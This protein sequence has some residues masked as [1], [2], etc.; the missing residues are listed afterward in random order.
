MLGENEQFLEDYLSFRVLGENTEGVYQKA[1]LSWDR[2]T[3]IPITELSKDSLFTWYK[4]AAINLS[5]VTIEKYGALCRIMY[6]YVLEQTGLSSRKAKAE[7]ADLFDV[8]PFKDLRK[9][10]KQ[11][12]NLRD[13][14]VTPHEFQ[15]L[16][17]I[18]RSQRMKAL[19]SLTYETGCRKAEIFSIRLKDIHLHEQYWTVLIEGK[20]GTRRIPIIASVPYLRAWLQIHPDRENEN[21]ALF[22]T[23]HKGG[24][25]PMSPGSF[26]T[27]LHLLCDR[28]GIRRLHPHQLRHTRLTE[29]AEDGLGDTQL[30]SFAG[31][32]PA[33]NMPNRYIHLSGAG[34]VN[35]VL[36]AG[37]IEVE[38]ETKESTP[39]IEL[40]R[41]PNCDKPIDPDWI[42]CPSCQFILNNKLGVKQHNELE[43]MKAELEE[44]KSNRT[45][46]DELKKQILRELKEG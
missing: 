36:E 20:T 45:N 13:M 25:Q 26:N 29:L 23:T 5:P 1:L 17:K 35:A 40:A 39:I 43:S 3:N 46:I 21:Q 22:V 37:G 30:R 41:C 42:Q 2:Y 38:Q 19:L 8:I 11:T 7:A 32:T 4:E 31:W 12:E 24:V 16:M 15:T 28:A 34:H 14:L 9:R 6:A 10:A 44:L 27:G 33:S 18:A